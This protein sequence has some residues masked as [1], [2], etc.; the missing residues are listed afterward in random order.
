[1]KAPAKY[2]PSEMGSLIESIASFDEG[3]FS[4][5]YS[6]FYYADMM[7]NAPDVK[8]LA[9]DGV[10]PSSQTIADKSYPLTN[11]F[12][13]ALSPKA[14]SKNKNPANKIRNYLLSKKGTEFIK[15]S[16]YI[17]TR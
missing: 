13:I 4:I 1:M 5:G 17:P 10:K 6:V 16:G 11:D 15:K 7:Y 3:G 2:V 9:V 12:Y 8:M 14:A